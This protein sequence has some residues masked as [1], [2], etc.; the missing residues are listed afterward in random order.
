MYHLGVDEAGRGPM[1]GPL[2][3]AAIAIPK[4]DIELLEKE[5]ITDSKNLTKK[6][7]E[8]AFELIKNYSEKRNW[9][10]QIT[11]CY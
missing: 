6:H 8:V 1:I 10:I 3:V 9:K 5:N 4:E 2:V 11:I 7:R